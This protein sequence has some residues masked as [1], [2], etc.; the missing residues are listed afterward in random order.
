M[1]FLFLIVIILPILVMSYSS[2]LSS[3]KLLVEK[4]ADLL[5]EIARQANSSVDEYL[6]EAEKISMLA[7]Y[8]VNSYVSYSEQ[9]NYPIQ[10]YLRD[11]NKVHENQVHRLLM[12]YIMMKD[13]AFSVYIYNLNGGRD[14]YISSNKPINYT[15]SALKEPWF[16][17][18]LQS[19]DAAGYLPTHR[20]LQIKSERNWAVSSLRKIFD[21]NNGKLLG[22]MVISIDLDFI[23]KVNGRLLES[24]R[25]AFT[26]LDEH[27]NIVYNSDYGTLGKPF[28][29]VFPVRLDRIDGTSGEAVLRSG[30][31]DYI[32]ALM[33]FEHRNWTTILHMPLGELS[34][35]GDILRRN[36]IIIAILLILFAVL[37]SYYVSTRI[38]RP[39]KILMRSMTSVERGQFE[40][41]PSIRSNDEIGLFANRFTLMSQ[42]LKRLVERIYQEEKEKAEAEIQALQAQINPHFLY[43]T[44]GSVKWIAS[45][46]RSDKIVQM[47]EALISML[48]Y[49]TSKVGTLVTIGDEL[50][51]IRH[52]VTIQKVRYYNRIRVEYDVDEGLLDCKILKLTIQPI[53]E[54]AIFHALPENDDD[55]SIRIAVYREDGDIVISVADNGIGMDR[56]AIE[57]LKRGISNG[58]E[59]FNGIGVGNVNSRI[60]KRF[61]PAYG[62]RFTSEKGKGTTFYIR[63]PNIEPGRGRGLEQDDESIDCR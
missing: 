28:A 29:D 34:A 20:D 50:E 43:N 35:E 42:E 6:N 36:L 51:N 56:A 40:P 55:G 12:N 62:V 37:S 4:Y 31:T 7:S 32:V 14:L 52:Y 25:T 41:L 63:I 17:A 18:F 49:T 2:Y 13:R 19:P 59:A 53:V 54:N 47:T 9:D 23:D 3:Q 38:T 33:P 45:M 15:Y 16:E 26:I 48:R 8:G 46:Q 1:V 39:I 44:L 5:Q 61:G 21:M 30:N 10:N 57:A 22:V 58:T 60:Q 24:R 27:R 11:S